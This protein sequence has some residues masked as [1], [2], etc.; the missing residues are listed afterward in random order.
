MN[1]NLTKAK[2]NLNNG[3]IELEGSEEFVQK[4]LDS[5]K[6]FISKPANAP[7]KEVKIAKVETRKSENDAI[8][9][10]KSSPV[11]NVPPE[12]F[13]IRGS[14]NVPSF[15]DFLGDKKLSNSFHN[16]I[17]MTGFYLKNYLNKDEFSEGTVMYACPIAEVERPK[18]VHQSFIDVKNK[19]QWVKQGS[20]TDKWILTHIGEDYVLHKLPKITK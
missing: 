1:E 19:K 16:M 17:V 8:K 4:N 6:D 18:R 5:F 7:T 11:D 9:Q 3:A 20:S 2:I 10:S 12:E 15:R 13:D 14:D